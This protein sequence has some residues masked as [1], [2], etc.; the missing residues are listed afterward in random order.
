MIGCDG[1]RSTVRKTLDIEFEGY[2]HPERFLVLT[3]PK[4]N[5]VAAAVFAVFALAVYVPAGYYL[6]LFLYRR[7]QRRKELGK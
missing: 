1:G 2:T 6:E 5:V 7:R 3:T 4:H